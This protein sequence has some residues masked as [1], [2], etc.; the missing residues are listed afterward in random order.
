MSEASRS[1]P[2]RALVGRRMTIEEIEAWFRR[3]D[4]ESDRNY[5]VRCCA[6]GMLAGTEGLT[7]AIALWNKAEELVAQEKAANA[8]IE[9]VAG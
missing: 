8:E 6:A 3:R 7:A 5:M 4:S 9:G 2:L 1:D